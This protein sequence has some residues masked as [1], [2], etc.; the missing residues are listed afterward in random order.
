MKSLRD[1]YPHVFE[2]PFDSERKRMTTVHRINGK[3]TSYTKGAVD[4]ML[5][6]C[7][8]I[9]TS[10]GVRFITEADRDNIAGLCLSM[11]KKT[12]CAWFCHAN[13]PNTAV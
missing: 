8:H 12:A 11:S 9:L 6:L 2:Q 10:E 13:T 4:E 7:T 5:P 3:W 1:K